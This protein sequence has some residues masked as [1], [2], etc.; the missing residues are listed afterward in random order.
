MTDFSDPGFC[1]PVIL[2]IVAVVLEGYPYSKLGL[3][4]RLH[5][6]SSAT[7]TMSDR[8]RYKPISLRADPED[9]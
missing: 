2:G 4:V 1:L 6:Y 8:H 5:L 3:D 7:A 9:T